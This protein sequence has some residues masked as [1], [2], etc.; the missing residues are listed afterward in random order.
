MILRI[1]LA[2]GVL[3]VLAAGG[4]VG[5]Q[6]WQSL[7]RQAAAAHDSGQTAAP[8]A[9]T[10]VAPAAVDLPDQDWL[11]SPGG[12]LVS[13]KQARVFLAQDRFVQDR[14]VMLTFRAP[15]A[16]LLSEGEILP[17]PVYHEALAELRA[18]ALAAPLCAPLVEVLAQGCAIEG[19][20]LVDDSYD[21]ATLT[22]EFQIT[23]VFT[24]KTETQPLPDLAAHVLKGEWVRGDVTSLGGNA[25]ASETLRDVGRMAAETCRQEMEAGNF[26]RISS[27]GIALRGQDGADFTI[28]YDRLLPL[29]QG[30]FPAPPLM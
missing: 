9:G 14:N 8:M 1:F 3:L 11:I 13:R 18:G 26:C 24:Q 2:L 10:Q 7:P 27:I 28:A 12:G 30:M 5:W 15:L 25:S 17:A 23:L 4:A 16:D 21:P 6:Y 19:A 22:A 29:P 20:R